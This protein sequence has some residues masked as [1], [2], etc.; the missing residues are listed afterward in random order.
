MESNLLTVVFGF[1]NR[2]IQRVKRCLNSLKSQTYNKFNVIFIDYGS[3]VSVSKEI[4]MLVSSFDF[5]KYI[6]SDTRGWPW[7]R[8]KALNI[9]IRQSE[10]K[11]VMTSDIDLIFDN[12]F[13]ER[14]MEH[15][16]ENSAVHASCYY[17]PP[18]FKRWNDLSK[19][20][21]TFGAPCKDALGLLLLL[22][23][24]NYVKVG[25]FDEYYQF[26]GV[27]DRDLEHRLIKSGIKTKWLDLTKC[28]LYHQWHPIHNNKTFSFMPIGYWEDAELYY[29]GNIKNV[30]R[31][32]D[33]S[34]GHVVARESR[35]ALNLLDKVI[36]PTSI[37]KIENSLGAGDV[38]VKIAESF[39]SAESGEAICLELNYN[40]PSWFYQLTINFLNRVLSRF[41]LGFQLS[42][43]RNHG[44]DI[45]WQFYKNNKSSIDDYAI[46]TNE[47]FYYFI[48]K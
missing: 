21:T 15:V 20:N 28:I 31:N 18:N 16:G 13:V 38:A 44:K 6:Y 47:Q 14:M 33:D 41:K 11:Y 17:L 9:G 24:E 27:E 30:V 43:N 5:C 40:K 29:G 34:W 36:A 39:T 42:P 19:L 22:S 3:D 32:L 25:G 7:N 8:S 10:T 37:I 2:D 45:F 1:K 4:S 46:S 12:Y 48:K 23:K 26:W 35:P